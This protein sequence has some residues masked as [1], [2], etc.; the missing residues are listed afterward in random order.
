MQVCEL[1]RCA[2]SINDYKRC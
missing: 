1:D 2:S